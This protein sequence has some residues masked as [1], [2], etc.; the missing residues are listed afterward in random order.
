ML[1][2]VN[3]ATESGRLAGQVFVWVALLAGALKCWSISRRPAT[4][5][6][7]ALSLMI[8]LLS[9]IV[10]G[11]LGVVVKQIGSSP[12]M[13]FAGGILGLALLA[14]MVTA[15]VLAI[16]GLVEFFRQPN[17]YSQGRA[18]AIW[19]LV[20]VGVFFLFAS[21][22]FI[23]GWQRAHGFGLASGQSQP[24]KMLAFDDLN[25]RFRSPDRPWVAYDASR[26]NKAS[27]LAFMRRNPEAYFFIIAEKLGSRPGLDTEQLAGIGQGQPPGGGGFQSRGERSALH[28]ERFEWIARGDGG[29]DRRVSNS[30]PALVLFHQ[31]LRLPVGGIFQ[32]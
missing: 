17:V 23:R 10:A 6:K 28:R 27:K 29:P 22:G 5:T 25:F 30:L 2:E 12:A 8:V 32:F 3:A 31:W 1:S 13:A 20:L 21:V 7:C 16:L 14:T 24:G 26:V 18:Q 4:N 11:S 9:L 19:T 15:I